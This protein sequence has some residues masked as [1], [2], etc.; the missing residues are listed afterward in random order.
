MRS[1]RRRILR[2]CPCV[3]SF[4]GNSGSGRYAP[5]ATFS[6]TDTISCAPL[7][8]FFVVRLDIRLRSISSLSFEDPP[9][10]EALFPAPLPLDTSLAARFAAAPA[11]P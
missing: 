4:F 6:C 10:A 9:A 3:S 1:A 11:V 2:H 5:S 7:H 8:E